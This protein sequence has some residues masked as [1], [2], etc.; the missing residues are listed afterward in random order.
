MPS[1]SL[2]EERS[3]NGHPLVKVT[4]PDSSSDFLVLSKYDGLEGHFIGHLRDEPEACVAMVHHLKHTEITLMSER[5]VGSTMYKWKANGEVELI[6]EVFSNGERDIAL[7]GY[8]N[9][10]V[11]ADQKMENELT[12][13][14]KHMTANQAESVP[15]TAK[16]Q[17]KVISNYLLINLHV[18]VLR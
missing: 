5:A 9:D 16:L 6:P 12:E 1:F 11:V 10:E 8:G 13:I 17:L 18:Y 7:N 4:F 14:E 15:S 3:E 2:I